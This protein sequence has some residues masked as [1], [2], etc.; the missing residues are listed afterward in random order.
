MNIISTLIIS[1]INFFLPKIRADKVHKKLYFDH[2]NVYVKIK[3]PEYKFI[4]RSPIYDDLNM[5]CKENLI[6]WERNS[7]KIFSDFSKISN[8]IFD[9]GAYSGIYSLIAGKVNKNAKIY[10]FEPNP[11]LFIA[12]EKNIRLNRL[13]KRCSTFN[14]ALSDKIGT[15]KFF[16]NHDNYT[17]QFSLV[18]HLNGTRFLQVETMTLDH[19]VAEGK[20]E[21]LDLIKI[22]VEGYEKF[23]IAGGT[24]AIQQ[25]KPIFLMEALSP[26]DLKTQSEK[27]EVLDYSQPIQVLG[28]EYDARN[29]FWIPKNKF[30]SPN[31]QGILESNRLRL[32]PYS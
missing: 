26:Q 10:S 32:V 14:Y 5:L 19:F 31:V 22:D 8:V 21:S 23:V 4:Y 7:R 9:I 1:L 24:E 13:Q 3:Y 25:F 6:N 16:Q 20:L 11:D 2:H 28:N 30:K 18:E 17:S 29:F 12:L 27:L 15:A